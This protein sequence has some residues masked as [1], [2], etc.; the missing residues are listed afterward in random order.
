M[1]NLE[2]STKCKIKFKVKLVT[3]F[4]NTDVNIILSSFWSNNKHIISITIV[5]ISGTYYDNKSLFNINNEKY[6]LENNII[7]YI[8][9][10]SYYIKEINY[11]IIKLFNNNLI[12]LFSYLKE[13]SR[14]TY[15]DNSIKI[16]YLLDSN[17][18]NKYFYNKETTYNSNINIEIKESNNYITKIIFDLSN[19]E[20]S[21]SKI[22]IEYSEINNIKELEFNKENYN[23]ESR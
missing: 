3:I 10:S 1:I 16:N 18:F 17:V 4:N 19:L 15:N 2:S 11:D 20:N 22:E 8:D 7:Y 12:E 23:L 14:T 13:V 5:N 6:Y 9:D 21:F